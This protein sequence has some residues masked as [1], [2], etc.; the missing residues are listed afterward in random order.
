MYIPAHF[1]ETDT[2]AV[3][4]LITEFPLATLV[5]HTDQGLVANHFPLMA[6]GKDRLVGHLALANDLHRFLPSGSDI[7]AIFQ[8]DDAYISPNWY[9]SKA[10]HHKVV[11]TWN[12][13]TVHIHGK[14]TFQHDDKSKI[15]AVGRLT[16]KHERD[17]NGAEAWKM[18]DAPKE[19][20][21]GMLDNI[22]AFEIEVTKVLAKSKLS[23]NRSSDD[24]ESVASQLN[25]AGKVRLSRK[26]QPADKQA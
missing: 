18:S 17:A 1:N 3:Q 23:Q 25:T 20:M 16:Q 7:M 5:A 15:A 22:V 14:I 2:D 21:A 6:V 9:P 24:I 12:Y 10:E 19:F 26:M 8:S 13:Q 11:P 4:A